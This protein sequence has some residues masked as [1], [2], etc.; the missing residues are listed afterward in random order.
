M[1]LSCAGRV[2]DNYTDI[3][4]WRIPMRDPMRLNTDSP[5]LHQS[6]PQSLAASENGCCWIH[7]HLYYAAKCHAARVVGIASA[8]ARWT[9]FIMR[10]HAETNRSS[11]VSTRSL[12]SLPT[13]FHP[14]AGTIKGSLSLLVDPRLFHKCCRHLPGWSSF[15]SSMTHRGRSL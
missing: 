3:L 2:V 14:Q 15:A 11:P 10:G 4:R 12:I 5:V 9:S 13:F 6:H 7:G 8:T 1:A